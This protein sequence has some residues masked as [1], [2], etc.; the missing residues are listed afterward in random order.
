MPKNL[1]NYKLWYQISLFDLLIQIIQ[2]NER[3]TYENA[4][5]DRKIKFKIFP[6]NTNIT[7]QPSKR[8]VGIEMEEQTNS[9]Q[10]NANQNQ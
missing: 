3:Q 6:F 5:G 9:N 10:D 2:Q 4:C 1:K 7:R 8:D